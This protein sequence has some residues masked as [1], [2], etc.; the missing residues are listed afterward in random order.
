LEYDAFALEKISENFGKTA[1]SLFKLVLKK[2]RTIMSQNTT[3][4][5]ITAAKI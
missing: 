5:V 1:A 3:I 4:H 2:I